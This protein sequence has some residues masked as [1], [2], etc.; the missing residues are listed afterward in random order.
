MRSEIRKKSCKDK[1]THAREAL[2]ENMGIYLVIEENHKSNVLKVR[3]ED[4]LII[5]KLNK[6]HK[7]VHGCCCASVSPLVLSRMRL[8]RLRKSR[9]SEDRPWFFGWASACTSTFCSALYGRI[10]YVKRGGPTAAKETV[11]CRG[12]QNPSLL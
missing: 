11:P 6:K 4:F 2:G 5:I 10:R 12:M 7:G 3:T 8:K 1:G 9:N